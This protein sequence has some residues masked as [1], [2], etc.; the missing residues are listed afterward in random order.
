M[1]SYVLL[2]VADASSEL[3]TYSPLLK[4]FDSVPPRPADVVDAVAV[5][6]LHPPPFSSSLTGTENGFELVDM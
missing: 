2:G 6:E 4:R 3:I 1:H 5:C